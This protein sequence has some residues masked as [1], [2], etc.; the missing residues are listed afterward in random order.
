MP[1]ARRL[2]VGAEANGSVH[3]SAPGLMHDSRSLPPVKSTS[4]EV[5]WP[6]TVPD[7]ISWRTSLADITHGEPSTFLQWGWLPSRDWSASC[8]FSAALY[9]RPAMPDPL[10][11][12]SE[13]QLTL[14]MAS[15]TLALKF[16]QPLNDR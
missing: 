5:W 15:V 3:V 4:S 12:A 11:V 8:A 14:G 1:G 6:S 16:V 10:P 9:T 2:A 13:E 7:A